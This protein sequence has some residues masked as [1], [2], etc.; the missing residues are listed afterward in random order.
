MDGNDLRALSAKRTWAL[1]VKIGRDK[2]EREPLLALVYMI[3]LHDLLKYG[4]L[5]SEIENFRDIKSFI[6]PDKFSSLLNDLIGE[7]DSRQGRSEVAWSRLVGALVAWAG[8]PQWRAEPPSHEN[9]RAVYSSLRQWLPSFDGLGI[10]VFL[11]ELYLHYRGAA[12]SRTVETLFC[13]ALVG[14]NS[15]LS[16][17]TA[18]S[19]NVVSEAAIR[20]RSIPRLIAPLGAPALSRAG[21]ALWWIRLRCNG[22][23]VQQ[24]ADVVDLHVIEGESISASFAGRDLPP[25]RNWRWIE[26]LHEIVSGERLVALILPSSSLA[27]PTYQRKLSELAS[28]GWIHGLIA[29]PTGSSK[30]ARVVL[31]LSKHER[32]RDAVL[33]TDLSSIPDGL[34][35][36][37][38]DK[39]EIGSLIVGRALGIDQVFDVGS[40]WVFSPSVEKVVN[41]EGL[42]ELAASSG[43][44]E[45]VEDQAAEAD[46][47]ILIPR[48]GAVSIAGEDLFSPI[49]SDKLWSDVN[50]SPGSCFYVIGD[51]GEGKSFLLA[52]LARRFS[53]DGVVCVAIAFSVND[54]FWS[55][56]PSVDIGLKYVY[57]GLLDSKGR[58]SGKEFE[59]SLLRDIE[60][61]SSDPA[62]LERL[63]GF[64]GECGFQEGVYLLPG[65]G[66]SAKDSAFVEI[67]ELAGRSIAGYKLCFRRK[68]RDGEI[69]PFAGLS[70]GERHIVHLLLVVVKNMEQ[71]VVFL[72]DEPEISLHAKWQR[73]MQI[74]F[75]R[76]S[77]ELGVTFVV[78]THSP[79]LIAG[80]NDAAGVVYSASS[81]SLQEMELSDRN[82]VGRALLDGF[83]VYTPGSLDLYEDCARIVST[84]VE[85]C[86]DDQ[87]VG[88]R[89][90]IALADVD[91]LSQLISAA[92]GY[93]DEAQRGKDMELLRMARLAIG[94]VESHAHLNAGG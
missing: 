25:S 64:L 69:V 72:V 65:G 7:K 12:S 84:A 58:A 81:G 70:S 20:S 71:G 30:S 56:K 37:L 27:R 15:R 16:E 13:A 10:V 43:L 57:R 47:S 17:S 49:R 2:E 39:A 5:K 24:S 68:M 50:S 45:Y 67:G 63:R 61:I 33:V 9:V 93:V 18:W 53:N 31:I 60:D 54:R 6:E 78:A 35:L 90:E 73:L 28:R 89:V 1:I 40:R 38:E 86:N 11:N 41:R 87:P 32:R 82:S 34:S 94:E 19:G 21:A 88:R 80:A 14:G 74:L 52:D 23:E 66:R 79:I 75:S 92:K 85:A 83:S 4:S 76:M 36:G 29:M 48:A 8:A 46:P 22:V 51:N 77:G 62:K 91:R 44:I 59:R 26:Q 42:D 55:I 3:C